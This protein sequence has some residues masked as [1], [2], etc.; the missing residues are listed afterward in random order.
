MWR[1]V[2]LAYIVVAMCYFPVAIIGYWAYGN[3]VTDNILTYVAKPTWVIAMA[4][5]MVV[6]HV[7][8]S[9]QVSSLSLSLSD[10][11]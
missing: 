5:L 6:I 11:F 9:Y 1:G 10:W 2:V 3:H 4:N 8:G 7:I